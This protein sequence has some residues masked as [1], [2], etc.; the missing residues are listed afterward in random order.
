MANLHIIKELIKRNNLTIRE[1]SNELGMTEQG[2]QKLIRE[3]S[4]KVDTLELIAKKLNVSIS[5]FFEECSSS[6]NSTIDSESEN[7]SETNR[8]LSETVKTQAR[9]IEKLAN[10]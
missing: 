5:I 3:N 8:N 9:I 7:L 4:T 2:L 1:F 6:I 10:K